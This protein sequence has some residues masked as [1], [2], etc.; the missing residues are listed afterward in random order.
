MGSKHESISTQSKE[1][2]N[3]QH[4]FYIVSVLFNP[5]NYKSR[6]LLFQEFLTRMEKQGIQVII[7][8]CIYADQTYRF[9]NQD[10]PYHLQLKT[11]SIL[12]IKENLINVAIQKLPKNWKYVA[13]IDADIEFKNKNWLRDTIE[14][15]KKY[16]VVQMFKTCQMLDKS[17]KK[18]IEQ[19]YSFFYTYKQYLK[20]KSAPLDPYHPQAPVKLSSYFGH[21]G[22]A[23]AATKRFF[24]G[25]GSLID[26]CIIGSAD[27]LMAYALIGELDSTSIPFKSL[28]NYSKALH[29]WQNNAL[30]HVQKKVHYVEGTLVHYWHGTRVAR[31]YYNRNNI[32]LEN[33]FDPYA[34]LMYDTSKLL[35][36]KKQG[37][38]LEMDL[39]EYFGQ[40][41]EDE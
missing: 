7:V 22:F 35:Q 32:L 39:E 15:L 12:W 10:N 38:K 25:V 29:I 36:Y 23:W 18:V 6:Y 1:P 4:G 19:Q 33:R 41:N 40:R 9:T 13:W 2:L 11:N 30:L 37:T 20:E 3:F 21:P 28:E 26:Y 31:N 34:D 24:E 5:C 8:E 27:T 17:R 16:E 14:A